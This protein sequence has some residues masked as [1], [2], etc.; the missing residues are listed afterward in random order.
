M[1]TILSN[2][3]KAA[4]ALTAAYF[5]VAAVISHLLTLI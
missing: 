5:V 4:N 3:N 1:R 2:Q